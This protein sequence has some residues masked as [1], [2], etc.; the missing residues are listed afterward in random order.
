MKGKLAINGGAPAVQE[1]L[2]RRWPDITQ[3]DKDAVMAVLDRNVLTGQDHGPETAALQQAWA[4]FTG[5]KHALAFNSGTAA[6]HTALFAAGVQPG[7]EVITTAFSFSGTCLPILQQHAIP[8]FVD[9]DPR[10]FN[11]D[12][13]KIEAKI[14][15]RTKVLLPVHMHGMPADMDEILAL[16]AK[17]DLVV[18]EDACQAH[19]SS[20]QGRMAGTIGDLGGFSL[21]ATKNL[22]G[23]EGGFLVT[24]NDEYAERAKMLRTF[25]EKLDDRESRFRSY[26][27]H[28]IGWN[29]RLQELPAAFAR[30]QLKR[31]PQ[32]NAIA[33]RNGEFLS[34]ELCKITGLLPPYVPDDRATNFH[35][36]RLSFDPD[37]LGLKMAPAQ[38]RDKLLD[39]L[40]AEGVTVGL[41]HDAPM[42]AFPIFQNLDIG[43]GNGYPWRAPFY[44]REISY[45]PDE[46]PQALR[47]FAT[48]L[49][50]NNEQYSITIQ[51]TA[52]MECY[53][54]AFHKVFDN[55]DE[56]TVA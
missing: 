40:E 21:N 29:Y 25:G 56:L 30:S 2:K 55:L 3:A 32:Y 27:C 51:D 7:D 45:N 4:A 5:S 34:R 54:D 1:G 37:A 14:T 41:W 20:Y 26:A 19:G 12:A 13:S 15:D 47:M 8:I 9:I 50:V 24:D 52:L 43:Y 39:A 36:Y 42:P 10:T 16:A 28:T 17:Y 31:L 48:S 38:F 44:D 18:V 23:G 53:L 11:I 49:V 22:S 46:Y 33:Q 6:L 35:K